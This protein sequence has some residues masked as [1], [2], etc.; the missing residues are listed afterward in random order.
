[1]RTLFA[2]RVVINGL[3]ASGLTATF[4]FAHAA[5]GTTLGDQAF[6]SG[7]M[8]LIAISLL[9]LYNVRRRLPFLPLGSSSSWLQLHVYTGLVT[10]ILF[11]LHIGWS[12]PNGTLDAALT[13]IYLMVALSGLFGL[14]V[15]RAAPSQLATRG[16]DVIFERI[17]VLR[18]RL[19]ERAEALVVASV[20]ETRSTTIADYY[21]DR[22]AA[23]FSD[24][25]N[26]WYHTR[27]ST[28]PWHRT[29][30][31]MDSLDRYLD[32]REHEILSEIKE[33][34]RA[35]DDLDYRYA[36]QA[37]MRRWQFV[38]V[39]LTYALLILTIA[40]TFLAYAFA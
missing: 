35:K 5:Y 33:L 24:A 3:V 39:P 29:S 40:H 30:A 26:F 14:A 2:R 38:H 34:A 19:R 11:G 18:R 25:R 37:L 6:L 1:M 36:M 21:A 13:I 15:A 27:Q 9:A 17:P 20:E 8:L 16:E 12:L 31:E 32:R 23:F 4:I 22:L 7:W 28:L 10:I